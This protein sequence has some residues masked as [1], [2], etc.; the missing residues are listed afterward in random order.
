M[1]KQLKYQRIHQQQ[2]ATLFTTLM[3][4]LAITIL[5]VSAA[6]ISTIDI[7]VASNEQQRM[8]LYQKAESMLS[9]F[10]SINQLDSYLKTGAVD[11]QDLDRFTD[12]NYHIDANI[13]EINSMYF[14]LGSGGAA[15]SLGIEAPCCQIYDFK[16]KVSHKSSSS[17]ET[18]YRGAGKERAAGCNL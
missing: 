6:R 5:S 14:C 8:M 16:V 3:I 2:G 17:V 11:Q 1:N 12:G 10:S 18:H 9:E 4:L 15:A 13:E 7:Q